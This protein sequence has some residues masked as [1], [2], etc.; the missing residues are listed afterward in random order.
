MATIPTN[1]NNTRG[2]VISWQPFWVLLQQVCTCAASPPVK[3]DV[4]SRVP[5]VF[6]Q[7]EHLL[8]EYRCTGTEELGD[9]DVRVVLRYMHHEETLRR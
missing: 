7:E 5:V 9:V 1:R 2:H 3:E 4:S 6:H 8:C